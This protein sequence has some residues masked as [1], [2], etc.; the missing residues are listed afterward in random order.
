MSCSSDLCRSFPVLDFL[1]GVLRVQKKLLTPQTRALMSRRE[2]VGQ[3]C[4]KVLHDVEEVGI[5]HNVERTE[6]S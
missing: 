4:F 1:G 3:A 5:T 6:G 2:L